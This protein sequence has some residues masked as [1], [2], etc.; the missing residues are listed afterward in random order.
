MLNPEIS[1]E[2]ALQ[3]QIYDAL[4]GDV[5][6][7]V[8]KNA[9]YT[10]DSDN[11]W[12]SK[13]EGHCMK[14]DE[15]LLGSFYQLCQEV[16]TKLGFEE[17]VDFYVTGDSSINAFSIAAEGDQ[18]HIVNVNS[19][20][21]N[22]MSEDELRFVVGHEL[23]HLI[24]QDTALKRLIWFVYPPQTTLPPV[25]LQYKIHLHDNLAELVA[26]RYGYLACENLGACVTA[27]FKMASG[28]DLERM[29]V[30]ISDLLVDNSKHL[31]YFLHGGGMSHYDHPVNPIRVEAINLFANA[32]NQIELDRGM[33]EL[34]QILLKVGNGPL[35]GPMS[36][37]LATSGIIA[38]NIDGNVTKEEYEHILRSLSNSNIF[39]RAFL[40]DILKKDVD[41]LFQESVNQILEYNPSLKPALLDYIVGVVLADKDIA[42]KEVNFIYHIGKLLGLSVKEISVIFAEQVQRNYVPSLDSI[43]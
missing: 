31:D 41:A 15:K 14:A 27:F 1:L 4:Q 2:K 11:Y 42:E 18:P 26:D 35:D 19:E 13:M 24:N 37:F 29:Q 38:A 5:V 20:L 21:F 17:P 22:L 10:S 36:V 28:L 32:E 8:L 34:I 40:D 30:G 23:G 3:N 39:P 16:K 7:F 9:E 25:T 12:R 6:K 43:S 33:D